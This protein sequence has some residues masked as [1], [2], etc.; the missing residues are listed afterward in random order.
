MSNRR[1]IAQYSPIFFSGIFIQNRKLK[2]K[3]GTDFNDSSSKPWFVASSNLKMLRKM[4]IKTS[5]TAV[6]DKDGLSKLNKPKGK[7]RK[8]SEGYSLCCY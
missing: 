3:L 1:E 2:N 7:L 8:N 6:M 5:L 4:L